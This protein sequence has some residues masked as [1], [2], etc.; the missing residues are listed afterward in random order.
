M[1]LVTRGM[2]S[3][4]L[5]TFGMG[6]S[7]SGVI[8]EAF[9]GGWEPYEHH[10]YN[11]RPR[12]RLRLK[13]EEEKKAARIIQKI[14]ELQPVIAINETKKALK[15]AEKELEIT[16]RLRLRY[17]GLVYKSIYMDWLTEDFERKQ[18]ASQKA[19]K[20]RNAKVFLLLH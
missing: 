4:N 15:Q 2:G 3:A 17:M 7:S 14:V 9:S 19:K 5:V 11:Y 1:S 13:D 12:R 16:L 6:A 10:P 20:Q 8:A 18:R